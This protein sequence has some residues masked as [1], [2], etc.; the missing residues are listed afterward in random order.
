MFN[1]GTINIDKYLGWFER[2]IDIILKLFGMGSSS[3]TT[4]AAP[5][6]TTVA[7]PETTT[8]A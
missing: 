5:E 7:V 4:T 2:I 3:N 8:V 1:G 6:T